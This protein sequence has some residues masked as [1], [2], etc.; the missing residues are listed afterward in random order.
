MFKVTHISGGHIS[1]DGEAARGQSGRHAQVCA[2]VPVPGLEMQVLQ[3][4][5]P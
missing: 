5:L 2:G 1:V 3:H 4:V